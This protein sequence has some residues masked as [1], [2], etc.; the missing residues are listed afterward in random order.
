MGQDALYFLLFRKQRGDEFV[1]L[2]SWNS[3]GSGEEQL[4][5]NS[6]APLGGGLDSRPWDF[7]GLRA[8]LSSWEGQVLQRS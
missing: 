4:P 3:P 1:F 2:P 8:T 6:Q 7:G 5:D